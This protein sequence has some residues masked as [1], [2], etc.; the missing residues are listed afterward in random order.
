[1][2]YE[3]LNHGHYQNWVCP[4]SS[5]TQCQGCYH[6]LNLSLNFETVNLYS[7]LQ[8]VNWLNVIDFISLSQW[9]A[10]LVALK[11]SPPCSFDFLSVVKTVPGRVNQH[12]NWYLQF[13]EWGLLVVI[14]WTPNKLNLDSGWS[15]LIS[16]RT[17]YLYCLEETQTKLFRFLPWY[18][19]S[20]WFLSFD[21]DANQQ[22]VLIED[23]TLASFSSCL[24]LINPSFSEKD[25]LYPY[26]KVGSCYGCFE[27]LIENRRHSMPPTSGHCTPN[28][29]TNKTQFFFWAAQDVCS[30]QRTHLG[31][32][33]GQPG[34]KTDSTFVLSAI[35][36][37]CWFSPLHGKPLKWNLLSWT[38][39]FQLRVA[40]GLKIC[41]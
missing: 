41:S 29:C 31:W 27:C 23:S 39:T 20:W 15:W 2:A 6:T 11:K 26:K 22:W 35:R 38:S 36:T 32:A 1:M 28:A 34:K 18:E 16:L 10:H 33:P 40:I 14:Y 21:K 25:G 5:K 37:H 7:A 9:L 30:D 19:C 12:L 24:P 4:Y 3:D 8:K 13:L 17:E